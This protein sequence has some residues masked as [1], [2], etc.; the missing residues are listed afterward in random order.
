MLAQVTFLVKAHIGSPSDLEGRRQLNA[1]EGSE[2]MCKVLPIDLV[3][4]LAMAETLAISI[5]RSP[6]QSSKL[7]NFIR[8]AIW[9]SRTR[10]FY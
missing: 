8:G 9:Q 1:S 2:E 7:C 5:V 3:S 4:T 6:F 10:W